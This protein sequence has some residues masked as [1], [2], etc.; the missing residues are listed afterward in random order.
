VPNFGFEINILLIK[1][2]S[3]EKKIT[4]ELR[5]GRSFS[6]NFLGAELTSHIYVCRYSIRWLEAE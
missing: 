2:L 4:I 3:I 5:F 1:I 6:F